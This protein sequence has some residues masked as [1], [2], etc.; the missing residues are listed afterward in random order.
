MVELRPDIIKIRSDE[1]YL[2]TVVAARLRALVMNTENEFRGWLFTKGT[3]GNDS[4][5]YDIGHT[6]CTI[7]N[8]ITGEPLTWAASDPLAAE[9]HGFREHLQWRMKNQAEDENIK[10]CAVW[11][12]NWT[13]PFRLSAGLSLNGGGRKGHERR[14]RQPRTKGNQG[15]ADEVEAG[16]FLQ[17]TGFHDGQDARDKGTAPGG[18]R[19]I[20]QAPPDDRVTERALGTV[21]GGFHAGILGIRPER[22]PQ[23]KQIATSL[24]GLRGLASRAYH[25][26]RLEVRLDS[27]ELSV[28]AGV[29]QIS[30][31][32]LRPQRQQVVRL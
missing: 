25:Q 1:R 29:G 9:I 14:W 5:N 19:A 15:L 30:L 26:P 17:A 28:K 13:Y 11:Q 22:V 18:V 12:M 20:R 2:D 8:K 16:P 10:T 21:V 32:D 31:A 3:W 4:W 23:A 7:V 27:R 6:R 24:S